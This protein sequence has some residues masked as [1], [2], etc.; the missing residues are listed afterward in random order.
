MTDERF[1]LDGL[2]DSL[3]VPSA[4]LSAFREL[5]GEQL[6]F[7]TDAVDATC[8]RRQLDIDAE[9]ERSIPALGR[10]AVVGVLR[11]PGFAPLRRV[12]IGRFR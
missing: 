5:S 4:S 1:A 6:R 10:R 11:G 12:M 8:E 3:H 9:L 2:A 7:L